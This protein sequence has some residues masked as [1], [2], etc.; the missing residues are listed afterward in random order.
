MAFLTALT[1]SFLVSSVRAL[2]QE[3]C[4]SFQSSA[5]AFSIAS[6]GKAAPLILSSDDWPG[7]QRA[8]QDFAA[9]VNRVTGITPTVANVSASA[10]ARS[11]LPVIIGTLGKSSLIDQIVNTTKLDVSS[12][13]NTWEAFM[14][15]VVEN[16]LPGIDKAYLMI[17][18]DKRGTIFAMYDHSEQFGVSPW[19]WWA[20]V[21]PAQHSALFVTPTGCS[22]GAPSV[23]YRGIF[24]NDEQPALQNWAAE[25]FTNGTGAALTGSP[26]NHLFYT[27]LFELM[28]RMKANHLWPAQWSSA[29]GVDDSV[30]QF[31][32]DYYGIV[33]GSSHEEPMMRSIPA[34]FHALA[35]NPHHS[36]KAKQVEWNLFGVGAWDYSVNP[37]NINAFWL[38]GTIRGAPYE[39]MWTIGMRGDGDEPI[40]GADAITLLEEITANQTAIFNQVFPGTDVSTIP[41]VWALYKEV[42]GYYDQGLRVNDY[43][44]LL[45]TDEKYVFPS[46]PAQSKYAETNAW[47]SCSW[48]NVRRYPLP[49]ERN[50]TGGAGIYYHVTIG[51]AAHSDVGDPR[52]YKWITS[53]QISKNNPNHD[54]QIFE[55]M[56]IAIE[57]NASTIWM[58]NVGDLKPYERETEFFI[59]YGWDSEK[60]NPDNLDTFVSSWAQREFGLSAADTETVTSIVANVT[61]FNARRK[62]ELM[63]S[64]TY[65]LVNYREAENVQAAWNQLQNASTAIYDKLSPAVQP[66]F[67]QLVHHAVLASANLGNM[68]IA[69]GQNN[70]RASQARLSAN[71]LADLVETLFEND[72]DLEMQ[73]H[74]LLDG[75][76]DHMMDQTHLGY[77]Y[78]QQPMGNSMPPITRVQKNKEALPGPMRISPEGSLASWP[79]DN[80][81]QCAAMFNCPPPTIN[82][83]QFDPIPNRFIDIGAGGPAPFTFT[84]V[85]NSSWLMVSPS[86]GSISPSN[87]EERVFVS[88]DW[89]QLPEGIS[90][91]NITFTAV[92]PVNTHTVPVTLE[93]PA[94][95]VANKTSVPAGFKGFVEA[96][97]AVAFEAEHATRNNSV[98]GMVWRT[99]PGLGRT[100]SGI[101][102]WPRLGNNENNFT[103]GT[104]P[105]V[106]YDFYTFTDS[107]ATITTYVSPSNNGLGADRPLGF[108]VQVDS[109]EP[110]SNYFFPPA[111]PGQQ[112]AAWDGPDGFA[113]NSIISVPNNVTLVSGVHTLKIFMIEP[114]VVVQKIVIDT[115]GVQPSY[116]GPP[117]SVLIQ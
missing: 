1:I 49:S 22:H 94:F 83:D 115:G 84:A 40:S 5:S 50:R 89:D 39:N 111:P 18:A 99:L 64:T 8:A 110:Q 26:F 19:Y 86:H 78:W 88:V 114:A 71:A 104:G 46:A 77:A 28:L 100:L 106:E 72:F 6:N 38:N 51:S 23:K 108:A 70:L 63:N 21:P 102:P 92:T 79:G 62:P 103:A 87:T 9:D 105:S 4:V 67:F 113:A 66:A 73:Y 35:C 117:E 16:P 52:D 3:N 29:F 14:T 2:G 82:M 15:R 57:R 34:S 54:S 43:V 69:A 55:Q 107:N 48:G 60:W 96:S 112:P 74:T 109:D 20:D 61:R 33:M 32:A 116:L 59:T 44:T 91:A 37:A 36:L 75:K 95:I 12:I 58:L 30:N 81:F 68:M 97:G 90:S 47:Y 93:Y 85:S 76:W 25:K 10:P 101:T 41:Q 53:S 45:W 31:M 7:V 42:E 13:E 98:A 65:S 17:G 56:S 11:S 80:M 24:L 27:K